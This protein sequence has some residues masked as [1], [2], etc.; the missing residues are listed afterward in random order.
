MAHIR[1]WARHEAN[2]RC[3]LWPSHAGACAQSRGSS[4]GHGRVR[5]CCAVCRPLGLL[6][7]PCGAPLPQALRFGCAV[8]FVSRLACWFGGRLAGRW[9]TEHLHGGVSCASVAMSAAVIAPVSASRRVGS[10]PQRCWTAPPLPAQDLD[11]YAAG[12]ARSRPRS[13]RRSPLAR[14]RRPA[15][16]RPPSASM[17]RPDQ[18]SRHALPWVSCR[19]CRRRP[20]GDRPPRSGLSRPS[21]LLQDVSP[22][23]PQHDGRGLRLQRATLR[24]PPL[25]RRIGLQFLLQLGNPDPGLFFQFHQGLPSP[26]RRAACRGPDLGTVG[27]DLVQCDQAFLHQSR[28]TARQKAIEELAALQTELRQHRVVHP[29]PAADPAIDRMMLA[30]PRQRAADPIPSAVAYS[31]SASRMRGSVAGRPG[32][33]PRALMR[34]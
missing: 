19:S 26:H 23:L 29:D 27:D 6:H 13:R 8:A 2:M 5:C 17:A 11:H 3:G 34:S 16:H 25:A 12:P 30:Q 4:G 24:Q 31:Q 15:R 10:L 32:I 1:L 7:C 21:A 22:T 18:S 9:R 14:Y 33:S 28:Q 20:A